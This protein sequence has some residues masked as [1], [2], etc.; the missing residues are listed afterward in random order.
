MFCHLNI[1]HVTSTGDTGLFI[2]LGSDCTEKA[3]ISGDTPIPDGQ[4]T[5]TA[6][7]DASHSLN[8]VR[9]YTEYPSTIDSTFWKSSTA[10]PTAKLEVWKPHAT[11]TFVL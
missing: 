5:G 7:V 6:G 2:P 3:L 1:S 8:K 10:A 11:F 4:I 9:L